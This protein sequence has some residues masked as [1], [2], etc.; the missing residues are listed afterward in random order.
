MKPKKFKHGTA[1]RVQWYDSMAFDGWHYN[2][3]AIGDT[4]KIVSMGYVVNVKDDCVTIT[5]SMGNRGGS[6]SP[7]S[8]PWKAIAKIDKLGKE[9]DR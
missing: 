6:L 3:D 2:T 1:I 4:A 5:T 9:W 7:V 8:I